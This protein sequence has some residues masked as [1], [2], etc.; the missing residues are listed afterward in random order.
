MIITCIYIFKRPEIVSHD[1]LYRGNLKKESKGIL[2]STHGAFLS[3]L[4]SSDP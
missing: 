4:L 2:S 3:S 1:V